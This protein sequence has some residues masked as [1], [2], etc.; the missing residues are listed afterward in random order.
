M[1]RSV[2]SEWSIT[3]SPITNLPVNCT[4]NSPNDWAIILDAVRLVIIP[5]AA[6]VSLSPTIGPIG[7]PVTVTGQGF[8]PNSPLLATFGGSQISFQLHHRC[9]RQYSA[10]RH[11]HRPTR[12][13]IREQHSYYYRQ[14]VQLCFS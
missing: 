7:M 8:A 3:Q 14:Q 2:W 6:P 13:T 9:F 12:L 4:L 11:L 10:W 5:P 1:P